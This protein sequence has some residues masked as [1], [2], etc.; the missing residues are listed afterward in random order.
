MIVKA[1]ICGLT[2]KQAVDAAVENG[3]DYV[4]FVFFAASP[5]NISA[6]D[7]AEISSDVP[8]NVEK[9]A[10]TVDASDDLI[11]EIMDHLRPDFIQC[12]GDETLERVSDIRQK[13]SVGVV[14][15]GAVRSSDDIAKCSEYGDVADILLFDARVPHSPLPGGNG[16]A[17]DWVLLKGRQ[18]NKPW[19]LSG[20]IN[21][22]N[23]KDA[24]RISGAEMVDISSGVESSPG[25]KDAGLIAEFMRKVRNI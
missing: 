11:S 17:F 19:F 21:I 18:F 8:A 22:E 5:R 20:G 4:G 6:V 25:V 2:T 16:V 1:K 23:I 13:F 7:A 15:A 24:V 10:V 9:I 12:H 14:K 3:A